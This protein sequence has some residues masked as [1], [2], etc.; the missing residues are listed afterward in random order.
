MTSKKT[1]AGKGKAP[2]KTEVA[3]ALAQKID[4]HLKRIENDPALNPSRF[5][6]KA[7]KKWVLDSTGMGVRFYYGAWA[8][9]DRHRVWVIYITYQ[10]GS[11]MTIEDAAKYLAW[12]DAGNEGRHFD[13]LREARS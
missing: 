1:T 7:R 10:G 8:R 3:A 4:A 5:F 12:L 6:D 11:Y 13:A 2:T 9:G